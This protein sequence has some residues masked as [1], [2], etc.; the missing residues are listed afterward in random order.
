MIFKYFRVDLYLFDHFRS[1]LLRL[2]VIFKCNESRMFSKSEVN[3]DYRRNKQEIQT[4]LQSAVSDI[5]MV[6]FSTKLQA[7]YKIIISEYNSKM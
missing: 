6:K 2:A 7:P 5:P 4:F 3:R 1:K